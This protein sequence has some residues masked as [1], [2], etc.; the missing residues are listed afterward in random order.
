MV[1]VSSSH[2][3]WTCVPIC[4]CGSVHD[5]CKIMEI[6]Y[7]PTVSL[8]TSITHNCHKYLF[9][10]SKHPPSKQVRQTSTPSVLSCIPIIRNLNNVDLGIHWCDN[11]TLLSKHW[12]HS[13]WCTLCDSLGRCKRVNWPTCGQVMV[14]VISRYVHVIQ[15]SFPNSHY[16]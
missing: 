2:S 4:E 11:L 12:V 3:E 15:R 13:S 16:L 1:W 6:L 10:L 5:V 9:H 14:V 7:I 8:E